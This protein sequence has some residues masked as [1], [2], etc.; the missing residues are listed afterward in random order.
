MK[1]NTIIFLLGLAL[2]GTQ[3]CET[4][5]KSEKVEEVS[6]QPVKPTAAERRAKLEQERNKMAEELRISFEKMANETPYYVAKGKRVYNK[7]ETAP[8]YP[9]GEAAMNEFLKSNLKYPAGLI[10]KELEGTVFVDFIVTEDGTV[11]ETATSSQ[12]FT[13]V[14][15]AFNEEAIRVV[16]LMPKWIPGRHEGKPVSVKFS[17]PITFQLD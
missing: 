4:K 14:D 6:A 3:A 17:L 9:G 11:Y 1:K 16:N 5:K 8:I 13:D 2:V 7:V 15:P 10:E 12:T